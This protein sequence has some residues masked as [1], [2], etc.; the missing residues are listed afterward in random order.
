MLILSSLSVRIHLLAIDRLA[1]RILYEANNRFAIDQKLVGLA[2]CAP[3]GNT[4]CVCRFIN[5]HWL[6]G[7]TGKWYS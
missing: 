5:V 4:C 7:I 1:N 6:P 2:R 3:L